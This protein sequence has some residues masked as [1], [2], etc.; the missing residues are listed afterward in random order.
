MGGLNKIID[1]HLPSQPRFVLDKAVVAGETFDFYHCN[2]LQCIEALYSDPEFAPYLTFA[3]EC[4]YTSP[5]QT[6]RIY[7][8]M[9]TGNW[10]WNTQV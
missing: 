1:N 7:H 6:E 3:P 2:I 9:E 8:D 5:D 10:W 4:R